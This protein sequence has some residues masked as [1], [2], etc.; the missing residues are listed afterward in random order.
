[1]LPLQIVNKALL[2][3]GALV[4]VTRFGRDLDE[5]SSKDA[6]QTSE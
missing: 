1:M 6:A 2:D 4:N 3:P 5:T